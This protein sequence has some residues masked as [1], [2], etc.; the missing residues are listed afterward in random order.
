MSN[1][2][3]RLGLIFALNNADSVGLQNSQNVIALNA[4][5]WDLN[6]GTRSWSRFRASSPARKCR[7]A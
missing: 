7:F 2:K 5:Y 4:N 6:D 3:Y 1:L